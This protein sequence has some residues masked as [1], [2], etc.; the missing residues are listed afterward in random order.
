ME[1]ELN[2]V[3]CWYKIFEEQVFGRAVRMLSGTLTRYIRVPGFQPSST[4]AC[5]F[6]LYVHPGGDGWHACVLVTH[7]GG[8]S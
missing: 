1:V 3:F 8:L 7:M 2:N 4:P 6:L 5:S